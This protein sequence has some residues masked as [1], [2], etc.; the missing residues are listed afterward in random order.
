MV[1]ALVDGDPHV[2][3]AGTVELWHRSCWGRPL[4]VVAAPPEPPRPRSRVARVV[5]AAI[6][7]S[8]LIAIGVA[9]YA[10]AEVVQPP[11]ASLANFDVMRPEAIVEPLRVEAY[12]VAPP[13]PVHVTTPLEDHYQMPTYDGVP[14]DE[15]YPSLHGWIHPVTASKELMP[16][17]HARHFGAE[18]AGIER[19]EC[20]AG[21]CGVDLDG[22]EGRPL[23]SVADGTI[24]RIERSELGLDHLSGR[25]IRIQHDDGTLT[26]YMHMDDV[27]EELAVG[28][29]VLAGQYIGT[30]G[31][32]AV[33][34]APPHCHFSVEIPN[35]PGVHG[36]T[37]DT[38]YIDPAP[39]L[40]R[41]TIAPRAE[42]K[43]PVKNAF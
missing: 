20:G 16:E 21:H 23:V 40:V 10:F 28:D 7:S 8:A 31:A 35:H 17:L 37:S 33:Y 43:H 1:V 22:P 12:E 41:A 18:R 39:F 13:K 27:A 3:A 42:R 15:K 29:R 19:P 6:G 25:Y 38:H 32:T 26:A 9:Q 34:E 5:L 4:E 14:L 2:T 11:V 36:D 30:L 24:V